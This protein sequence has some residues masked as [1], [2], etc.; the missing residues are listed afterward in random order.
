M[1]VFRH[2]GRLHEKDSSVRS[3]WPARYTAVGGIIHFIVFYR[4]ASAG[5][6]IGLPWAA[7]VIVRVN[8]RY[9]D[10]TGTMVLAATEEIALHA[11]IDVSNVSIATHRNPWPHI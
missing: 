7:P 5:V 1:E 8:S 6:K 2:G 3:A 4:D 9:V 11:L 10:L